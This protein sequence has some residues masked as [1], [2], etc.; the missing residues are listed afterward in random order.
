[1]GLGKLPLSD[2]SARRNENYVD[3]RFFT[4]ETHRHVISPFLLQGFLDKN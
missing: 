3:R 1:L 4:E 2:R